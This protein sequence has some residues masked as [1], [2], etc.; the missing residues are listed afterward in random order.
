MLVNTAFPCCS[1]VIGCHTLQGPLCTGWTPMYFGTKEWKK[2]YFKIN[3]I[4]PFF[5]TPYFDLSVWMDKADCLFKRWT[6]SLHQ[7]LLQTSSSSPAGDFWGEN[8]NFG[9]P[10]EF[11]A[12][13]RG[14]AGSFPRRN[15]RS[16]FIR[17]EHVWP[18]EMV[19]G[20][21]SRE[22]MNKFLSSC[23]YCTD[24]PK[25]PSLAVQEVKLMMDECIYLCWFCTHTYL[26]WWPYWHLSP[27][28]YCI[29]CCD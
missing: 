29:N 28:Q 23:R 10:A 20:G 18:W 11:I 22:I 13:K 7:I 19:G 24:I 14:E 25:Q 12:P 9:V 21:I 17:R 15:N 2:E 1:Q 8:S 4:F 27:R 26:S 3:I 16:Q 6:L 5:F